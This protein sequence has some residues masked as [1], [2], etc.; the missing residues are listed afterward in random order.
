MRPAGNPWPNRVAPLTFS[1]L[2]ATAIMNHVSVFLKKSNKFKPMHST[3]TESCPNCGRELLGKYCYQCGQKKI[4]DKERTLKHF[5]AEFIHAAFHLEHNILGYLWKLMTKPGFLVKEYIEGRRK[6]HMSPFTVFAVINILYFL[7]SPLTDLSLTLYD[8]PRQYYGTVAESLINHRLENRQVSFEE[9]AAVYD[10]RSESLSK[11]MVIINVPIFAL[12]IGLMYR[13]NKKFFYADH[14]IFALN[15]FAFFLLYSLVLAIPLLIG[16]WLKMRMMWPIF[17][18]LYLGGAI[19]YLL[20]A[21]RKVYQERWAITALKF[22]VILCGFVVT[23][24]I[25][26][27]ILFTTTFAVT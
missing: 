10:H 21:L 1:F 15:F 7:F 20:F 22:F 11:I 12:F 27:F 17:Q 23:H 3:P 14:L 6:R 24:F 8:Q 2:V 9:Y 25:Y 18:I 13:Q 26:R 19:A 5:F 16:V 4:D